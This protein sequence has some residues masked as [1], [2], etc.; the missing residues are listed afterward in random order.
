MAY[1]VGDVVLVPFPFT[2]LSEIRVRPAVVVSSEQFNQ[3]SSDVTV[4]MIT[5]QPRLGPTDWGLR[6]WVDAGLRVPSWVRSRLITL[7]QALIRFSPG[8]LT[9]RDVDAVKQRLRLALGLN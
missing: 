5:S 4:A 6:D 8:S 7:D 9:P 3:T 1:L 2:D